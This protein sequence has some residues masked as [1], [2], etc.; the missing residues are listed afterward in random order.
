MTLTNCENN[1]VLT[2][3]ANCVISNAATNQGTTFTLS[4]TKL[5]LSSVTLSTDDNINYCSKWNKDS[6]VQLTGINIS[7]NQQH[8]MLQT[9]IEII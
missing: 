9:N 8:R 7:Q 5:Y 2:W 4:D 6:N 3:S 1:L